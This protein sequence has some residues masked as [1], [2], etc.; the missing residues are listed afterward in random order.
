MT[1]YRPRRG[2]YAL[3]SS[4]GDR[5]GLLTAIIALILL[6]AML[7][8]LVRLFLWVSSA[9]TDQRA[10]AQVRV[11]RG[12]SVNVMID[13]GEVQAVQD[14]LPLYPGDTLSTGDNGHVRLELFDG[15]AMRLDEDT[16]LKIVSSEQAA[17]DTSTIEVSLTR[18]RVW[19]AAPAASGS[20]IRSVTTPGLTFTF[21]E[22]TEAIVG[23]R[24][25]GVYDGAGLGAE[26]RVG[27]R[28]TA[29]MVGEGQ[30]F[31]LPESD[32]DI[33]IDLY[34]YRSPLTTGDL[35]SQFLADSRRLANITPSGVPG[36][37]ATSSITPGDSEILTVTAPTQGAN[38]DAGTVVVTG[39]VGEGVVRVRVN[40]YQAVLNPE[41]RAFSQELAIENG[42]LL[43]SV[44][45][46]DDKGLVLAQAQRSITATVSSLPSPTITAPA[47][48]GQIYR[49]QATEI[50]LRGGVP[51]GTAAVEVNGYRLQLFKPGSTTWSYLARTDLQNLAAG[52]NEFRVVAYTAAS[53]ASPAAILVVLVE[54]GQEGVVSTGAVLPGAASSSSLSEVDLPK[55]DPIRAGSLQVTGPVPGTQYT[56]TGS[57]VLIEGTTIPETDSVWVNGY[58]LQLYKPGK[59]TWNTIARESMGNL[60]RGQNAYRIVT[61]NKDNAILDILQYN[62]TY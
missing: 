19:I 3:S 14:G 46:L 9:G 34:Q 29:V 33:A 27:S 50:T 53:K 17:D 37:S 59:T 43:V 16:E 61:R 55:N 28:S 22:R 45:A 4:R 12:G 10:P 8:G 7:Y 51:V 15:T 38:V 35:S 2:S 42:E 54:S 32:D 30:A 49:T 1:Q 56:A 41:T 47:R 31:V 36:A 39:R 18:G 48:D 44:E 25:V 21:P 62:I 20:L 40:G 57:E 6:G 23:L 60:K 11:E 26:L 5:G 13:G 58:K 52:R 24:Q